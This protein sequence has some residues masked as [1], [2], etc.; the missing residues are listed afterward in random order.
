[1]CMDTH[2]KVRGQPVG[3][4]SLYYVDSG[5]PTQVTRLGSKAPLPIKP[6]LPRIVFKVLRGKLLT[7]H[8]YGTSKNIFN[9]AREMVQ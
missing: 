2:G 5:A 6:P 3:V 4:S 7:Y 9:G 1:M 8:I